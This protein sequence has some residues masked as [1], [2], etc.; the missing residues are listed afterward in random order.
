MRVRFTR[1]HEGHP[2]GSEA[3]LPDDQ[4]RRAIA[5]GAA[6]EA[7]HA[8]GPPRH[9]GPGEPAQAPAGALVP[10]YSLPA[11]EEEPPEPG[12]TTLSP[13]E[14]YDTR[15]PEGAHKAP[16]PRKEPEGPS[17]TVRLADGKR[18]RRALDE[19]LYDQLD[20]GEVTL[21]PPNQTLPDEFLERQYEAAK[22]TAAPSA[23]GNARDALARPGRPLAPRG[24]GF[25]GGEKKGAPPPQ[26]PPKGGKPK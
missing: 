8:G 14:P 3:E 5:A 17:V 21:D 11:E 23:E 25:K 12:H 20:R 24:A 4:A 26:P 16:E 18:E 10:A 13:T 9:A 1:H 6:E 15:A 2:A 22:L 7:R 19:E